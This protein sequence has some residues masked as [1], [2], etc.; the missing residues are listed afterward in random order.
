MAKDLMLDRIDEMKK[1]GYSEKDIA[2]FFGL[3]T[4]DLRLHIAIRRRDNRVVL[5]GRAKELKD[6]G[7]TVS[8]IAE[9]M[10]KTESTVR[11]LLEE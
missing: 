10:K 1:V 5:A 4:V 11:L 8:E 6:K 2:K 7:M 3:S 9:S